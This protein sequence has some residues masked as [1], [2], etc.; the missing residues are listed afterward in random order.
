MQ[1]RIDKNLVI[2]NTCFDEDMQVYD[3]TREPFK[4]YGNSK[5]A[6]NS[7]AR[8]NEKAAEKV[9]VGVKNRGERS[10]GVRVRFKTDS[11]KLGIRAT[12]LTSFH[13]PSLTAISA[14]GFDIYIGDK[15]V[16][17]IFP[18]SPEVKSK[19]SY[20]QVIDLEDGMKDIIIYFPYNAVVKDFKLALESR[21][22]VLS[23]ENY[24]D[25]APIVFYGSS[26]T[27]GFCVSRPGVTF[28]A[29]IS[30]NLN[31]DYRN[32]GFSGAARGEG[33][34]A[35]YLAS[36]DKS[37]IVCEY[38]HNEPN[39]EELSKRHLPF[40]KKIRETDKDTPIL[41]ISRPDERDEEDAHKRMK[42][43]ESTY[44]Y[45]LK[46]G[47]KNVYFIDG[48]TLFPDEIRYDCTVDTVHP[49]DLGAHMIAEEL[50]KKL[51]EILSI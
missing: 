1:D 45:A 3:V 12:L 22:T 28:T 2:E 34:M 9:S 7:F 15:F 19:V 25:L 30:R 38:D 46:N 35:E 43:V 39:A 26:I 50:S 5:S 21:A 51:K 20:E 18:E 24:R 13:A 42:I 16:K 14:L 10:A 27:H 8:M 31:I 41:F 17:S 32:L 44:N 36:L 37:V 40:Y 4:I 33:A 47:D 48:L 29:K 11:K 23:A 49:N 6:Q